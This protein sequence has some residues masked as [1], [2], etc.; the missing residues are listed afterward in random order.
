M[1]QNPKAIIT[2]G[3]RGIGL[4]IAKEL[5]SI[6]ASVTVCSRNFQELKS[7][8]TVLNKNGHLA[9]GICVDV[10][11]YDQCNKLVKFALKKVGRIDI[12]VNNAGIYG[13]IGP[14]E[15]NDLSLWRKTIEV[16]LMGMVY[17]SQL[18]IP[19]MKKQGKGKIINL[20]GS[21][22]GSP[23]SLPRFSAYYTSKT[24]VAGFTEVIARE[25]E[26]HN[27]QVNAVFPGA[28][29]TA[30]TE[31]LLKV[32]PKRAGKTM[33]ENALKQKKTGGTQPKL[34][35]KLTAFLASDNANHLTGRLLSAKWDSVEQ[36]NKEKK[37]SSSTYRLR[38]ID[39]ALFYEKHEK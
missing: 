10:S 11:K 6:G 1:I 31:Y 28:V 7:A 18:V 21:G 9:N 35:A 23:H 16:N 12:L 26:D 33:Y 29:N 36:L 24:A 38:R 22:V 39:N 37:L 20:C 34:V 13:P 2:G 32:G 17:C 5:T 3:T 4:A 27:I 30:M 25:L 19:V 15:E 14:L 8:L